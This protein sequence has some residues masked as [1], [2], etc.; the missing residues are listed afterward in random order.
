M[1]FEPAP[2]N[3]SAKLGVVVHLDMR[4][5]FPLSSVLS[6]H[7]H[8]VCQYW[9]CTIQCRS[10]ERKGQPPIDSRFERVLLCHS[11]QVRIPYLVVPASVRAS[12]SGPYELVDGPNLPH[13]S[14]Y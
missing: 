9:F 14:A 2:V 12:F 6:S 1:G 10:A 11:A 13:I 5:W 3:G 7:V 4:G 8:F